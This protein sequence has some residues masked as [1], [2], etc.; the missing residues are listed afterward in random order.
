MR[1]DVPNRQKRSG[2]AE[3]GGLEVGGGTLAFSLPR[4]GRGSR[5]TESQI[6]PGP[7]GLAAH[8]TSDGSMKPSPSPWRQRWW[9]WGWVMGGLGGQRYHADGSICVE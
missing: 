4:K 2:D 6:K 3:W 9:W 1:K 7:R 8:I 5:F